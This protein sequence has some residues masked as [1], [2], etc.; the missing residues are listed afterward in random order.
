M[1][2]NRPIGVFDS[3]IGG[4][5]VLKAL[6]QVLPHESYIYLGDTARLPYGTKTGETVARYAVQA[7]TAL[8]RADVKVLV[9]ACNTASAHALDFLQ[10]AFPAIPVIGV[11]EPGAIVAASLTRS[12]SIGVMSTEST[13]RTGAYSNA[14]YKA[15]AA[16]RVTP[17]ACGLMVALV[18]EG[19]LEGPIPLE[20][21]KRYLD[22]VFANADRPDTVIL[23][24]THFPLL[25]SAIQTAAGS[26]VTLIDSGA[27]TAETVSRLLEARSLYA[28]DA[29]APSTR[30]LATDGVERFAHVARY[31]LN[32]SITPAMIELV[33]I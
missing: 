26:E 9:I 16:A 15:L 24:C 5:T 27:V 32:S 6:Q 31:F 18:E 23:G 8:V 33:D 3:G 1:A 4:L 2:D 21:A 28:D 12:G 30:F 25:R 17:I 10:A 7:A 20:V 29:T 19:W 14:I 13:A 11:I 22:P